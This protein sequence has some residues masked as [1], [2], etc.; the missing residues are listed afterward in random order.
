MAN[1]FG[2]KEYKSMHEPGKFYDGSHLVVTHVLDAGNG[3]NFIMGK[4]VNKP[5]GL[6]ASGLFH[7]V[8]EYTENLNDIDA[9]NDR[10][11]LA[12]KAGEPHAVMRVLGEFNEQANESCRHVDEINALLE[13]EKMHAFELPKQVEVKPGQLLSEPPAKARELTLHETPLLQYTFR[14]YLEKVNSQREANARKLTA[15][16]SRGIEAVAGSVVE[17]ANRALKRGAD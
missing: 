1:G 10:I 15:A 6:H 13:K 9:W 16:F 5:K 2:A 11:E 7:C 8:N 14:K 4:L 12:A 17:E 3:S